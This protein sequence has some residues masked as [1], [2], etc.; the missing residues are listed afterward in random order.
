MIKVIAHSFVVLLCA[1]SFAQ[2][3]QFVSEVS[4]VN[5]PYGLVAG[6][7]NRGTT[8]IFLDE[9]SASVGPA[10][11]YNP[12][13]DGYIGFGFGLSNVE[14]DQCQNGVIN[15]DDST[16]VPLGQPLAA[17]TSDTLAHV[18]MQP[19][20]PHGLGYGIPCSYSFCLPAGGFNYTLTNLIAVK[21]CWAELCELGKTRVIAP[22]TG[23]TVY[24]AR[25]R[26]SDGAA[27]GVSGQA[28]VTFRWHQ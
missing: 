22:G 14:E 1:A 10:V 18:Q 23:V 17:T 3:K 27:F 20:T 7:F 24:I 19:C 2:T 25:Y 5:P 13:T 12:S 8:N 21:N 11:T 9:V 16:R 6:I 4:V 15:W 28:I 26:L